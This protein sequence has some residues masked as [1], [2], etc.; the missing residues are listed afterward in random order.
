MPAA[1]PH[2]TFEAQMALVA[3]L[4]RRTGPGHLHTPTV[5]THTLVLL[6]SCP[7]ILYAQVQ[8]VR[9]FRVN[10]TD[11]ARLRGWDLLA[12]KRVRRL[13][14]CGLLTCLGLLDR[15][16]F[17]CLHSHGALSASRHHAAS[18]LNPDGA[19]QI[20][21]PPLLQACAVPHASASSS[22]SATAHR[23]RPDPVT[24]RCHHQIRTAPAAAAQR[25]SRQCSPA[26]DPGMPSTPAGFS[27]E[28]LSCDEGATST[29][30]EN[31]L[32]DTWQ[33]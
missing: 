8:R 16:F 7:R 29:H 33:A 5:N 26:G 30:H 9:T 32:P 18:C 4:S 22:H 2:S 12:H 24:S 20:A 15:C 13:S 21:A 31:F 28:S 17:C 3:G 14:L 6:R 25:T 19:A 27:T 11:C 10:H 23:D 1:T